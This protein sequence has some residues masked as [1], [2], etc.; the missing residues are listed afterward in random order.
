MPILTKRYTQTSVGIAHKGGG[1]KTP[2]CEGEG[3]QGPWRRGA[4]AGCR[5][6]RQLLARYGWAVW[7]SCRVDGQRLLQGLS[8]LIQLILYWLSNA[9]ISEQQCCME[10]VLN[11]QSCACR[12]LTERVIIAIV[13]RHHM[14]AH[15]FVLCRL[16]GLSCLQQ[17]AADV[18]LE[19]SGRQTWLIHRTLM[20]QVATYGRTGFSTRIV[21]D[22]VMG[23]DLQKR[24]GFSLDFRISSK[25]RMTRAIWS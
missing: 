5:L 11:S 14:C 2:M 6:S 22:R 16:G 3:T 25:I 18:D 19:G 17:H 4:T 15:N 9:R 13:T 8:L 24:F 20:W 7:S 1:P 23:L 21:Y 12:E 10:E